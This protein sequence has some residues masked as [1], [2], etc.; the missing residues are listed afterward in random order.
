VGQDT[1]AKV[2]PEV[3]AVWQAGARHLEVGCGVGN[4][5]LGTVTTYQYVSAVGIE[6]D[7]LTAAEAERRAQLLGVAD[8]TDVRRM[9][10]CDLQEEEAFD[11][12]QWSQFS[13]PTASRPVVLRA[14]HRALRPGGYLFMP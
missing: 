3:E 14:M 2:M 13:F 5:L 7:E 10:S 12:V 1:I 9:D 11:M 4:A 8:R 6:I